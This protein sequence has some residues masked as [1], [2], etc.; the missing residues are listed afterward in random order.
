MNDT[1]VS[2]LAFGSNFIFAKE[3][4]LNLFK[5]LDTP[6]GRGIKPSEIKYLLL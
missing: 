2:L 4:Y 3:R 1:V 5:N 6:R